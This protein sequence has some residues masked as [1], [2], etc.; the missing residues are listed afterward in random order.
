MIKCVFM[1]DFCGVQID[2]GTIRY[3]SD[4]YKIKS[5]SINGAIVRKSIVDQKFYFQLSDKFVLHN[6]KKSFNPFLSKTSRS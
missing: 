6:K 5:G 2:K 1:F 4:K 3:L